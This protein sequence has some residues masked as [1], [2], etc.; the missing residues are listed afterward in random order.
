MPSL[1]PLLNAVRPDDPDLRDRIYMPSLR[2]LPPVLNNKVFD[3]PAWAR[4][5]K[6]QEQTMACTGFAT[7]SMIEILRFNASL[8]VKEFAPFMLYYMALRYDEL[9]GADSK[10]GS[11]IR[12][13]MKAWHKHGA[14]QNSFWG[15]LPIE[16]NTAFAG[17]QD[18]AFLTPLGAYYRVDHTSVPDMHAALN[19]TGVILASSDAHDGWYSPD[20]NGHITLP[21]GAKS[22]GGHAFLIVGYDETGFWIQN[23]WGS[24]WG[25]KGFAHITYA[26]W[27]ERGFDAWIGQLGV[28]ISRFVNCISSGLNF[29]S[30]RAGIP[31]QLSLLSTNERISA[32]QI[33]HYIVNLQ[34]NG[35]LSNRGQFYTHEDDLVKLV[36]EL[37]PEAVSQWKLSAGEE[38][39]VALYAHGGL[40]PEK[41]AGN[42]ARFWLPELYANKIFPVFFMWET[43]LIDTL[44]DIAEDFVQGT[45]GGPAQHFYDKTID[46]LDDRMEGLLAAPGTPIWEQMKQNADAASKNPTGG[47]SLL[48]KAFSNMVDKALAKRIR[49]HL[50]GHSAGAEFHCR[51]L[52]H[53]ISK[54]ITV[55]S[56][57]FMAPACTIDVF[58]KTVLKAFKDRKVGAY[59]QF[60]LYD[61]VERNDNCHP[62]PYNKSLLYLVSNSFE[63][64]RNKPILGMERYSKSVAKP[65]ASAQGWSFIS[66]PTS[67]APNI[68]VTDRSTST[69]HGGFDN[70]QPTRDAVISRIVAR[71]RVPV[72][73]S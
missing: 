37:L 27:N 10:I 13:A 72:V 7:A 41:G 60:Q 2:S 67:L 29:N 33:N 23:S 17:W 57:N 15:A 3:D 11:T 30:L 22:K 71:R 59:T 36:N 62:L 55:D 19:E 4:R 47:L 69:R 39:D 24:T 49:L 16:P 18:D 31:A 5:V 70:D 52:P 53:L 44:V 48:A 56:I 6:N 50:I 34:N 61:Q 68:P 1:P 20:V 43:G 65:P 25:K 58:T 45:A 8:P 63:R 64:E 40:T 12:G 42:I 32:Q 73:T 14:C 46:W 21:P 51:L 38:I 26:E 9:P 28:T 66:A 35:L 54:G